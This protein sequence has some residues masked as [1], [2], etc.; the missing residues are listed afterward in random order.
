VEYVGKTADE[1]NTLT[2][3][4]L[5]TYLNIAACNIKVKS[6][7]EAILACDEALKLDPSNFRALY[8]KIRAKSL[9]KNVDVPSLK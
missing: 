3:I 8:R 6:Y 5:N 4:K 7:A 2:H 1:I 9:P